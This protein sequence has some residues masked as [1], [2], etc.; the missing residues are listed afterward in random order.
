MGLTNTMLLTPLLYHK[1]HS[2]M[3]DYKY[4]IRFYLLGFIQKSTSRAENYIKRFGGDDT[5][6]KKNRQTIDK[7]DEIFYPLS[8]EVIELIR[9]RFVDELNINEVAK[10]KEMSYSAVQRLCTEPIKQVKK[11]AKEYGEK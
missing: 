5:Q 10:Q 11:I 7:L 9:L 6:I 2:T 3:S 8:E 4:L 1:E